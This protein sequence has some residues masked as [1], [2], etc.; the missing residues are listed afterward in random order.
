MGFIYLYA[1]DTQI[2]FSFDVHSDK[3]D[4]TALKM[5]FQEI[6]AWMSHNFMM[7]NDD[8]TEFIDIGYYVSPLKSIE[9]LNNITIKPAT[10]AKNLGFMFDHSMSLENQ[11]SYVSQMCYLNL[12]D[13]KRI[14]CRL[15]H[16]LKVQLVQSNI[17]SIRDYCNATYGALTEKNLNTLQVLQ[18]NAVRFI[19][20]LVGKKKRYPIMPYLKKLHFLPVRYRIKFKVSLLVFKCLNGISPEYLNDFIVPRSTKRKSLR[21]DDDYFALQIPN[22]P[23]FTRTK[24]AFSHHGPNLWNEL[25]YNIRSITKLEQFKKC[26]K[27]LLL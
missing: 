11:I 13:L 9:L 8:K 5:C 2:Y 20:N 16:D 21:L 3:I 12:R 25:P 6:K 22:P 24:A 7:L 4:L 17:L 19:F 27:N 26:L 14:A 1:D 18:N 15:N 23:Q 10:H